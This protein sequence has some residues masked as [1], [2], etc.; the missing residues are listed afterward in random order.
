MPG[1]GTRTHPLPLPL[2]P[3][4]H[5]NTCHQQ[6]E[7]QQNTKKLTIELPLILKQALTDE[8]QYFLVQMKYNTCMSPHSPKLPSRLKERRKKHRNCRPFERIPFVKLKSSAVF[9]IKSHNTEARV[10]GI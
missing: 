1:P 2:P 3:N 7:H 9:K 10:H 8:R 6:Q 4:P 5:T